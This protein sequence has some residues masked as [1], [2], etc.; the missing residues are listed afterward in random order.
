MKLL[1]SW[2]E[3]N[4]S[5]LILIPTLVGE[6]KKLKKF[7]QNK[8][9]NI[10]QAVLSILEYRKIEPKSILEHWWANQKIILLGIHSKNAKQQII[11][12]ARSAV[13]RSIPK[14]EDL[15]LSLLIPDFIPAEICGA[16]VHGTELGSMTIDYYKQDRRNVLINS[17]LWIQDEKAGKK[18]LEE[19]RMEADVIQ[20]I[21]HLVNKPSNEKNPETMAEW[22][23]DRLDGRKLDWQIL[24]FQEL[25]DLGMGGIVGV[26][27][28][29]ATKPCLAIIQYRPK[30]KSKPV[31]LGLVGKGVT[32]DTGGISL[33]DSLNMHWMKSDMA[34]AAAVLGVVDLVERMEWPIHITA[35]IP[36]A[37]NAIDQDAYRPGDVL[38]AYN[39]K[40][41]EIID[42]DAEGRLIL[43]D[44]LAYMASQFKPDHIIDLA[45]LTGSSIMTLG[46][47]AAALYSNNEKLSKKLIKAGEI[48]GEKL[49]QLPLWDEYADE[50]ISDIADIK[51]LGTRPVAGATTAA[52]F[53][54]AFTEKHPSW[55]HLDIAG[56]ALAENEFAKHRSATA[57]GV[58]LLKQFISDLLTK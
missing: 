37:E 12:L 19:Y 17:N 4:D 47:K 42:T 28:G 1:Q 34:G 29:S 48:T 5:N 51:N 13:F 32:F 30:T 7:F 44:A 25:Q 22:I 50:L 27:K 3:L 24:R 49:W 41:I 46:N 11:Q 6:D 57:Y 58:L 23:K 43:A 8:S 38:K 21:C 33:K 40:T 39:G 45:T 26:G 56:V 54:Q 53:L 14:S 15:Q 16:L 10:S 55:A 20:E 2:Q 18:I 9:D 31:H 36:F 52:K 35:V